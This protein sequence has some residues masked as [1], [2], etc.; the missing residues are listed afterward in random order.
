M[1]ETWVAVAAGGLLALG[2]TLAL[3]R[4]REVVTFADEREGRLAIRVARAV[5]CSPAEA[6]PAVRREVEFA[7]HQSDDT[8]VK[9]AV[10][11][12]RRELP[13]PS[14]PVYPD[15]APG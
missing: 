10:Y 12:Y 8:L 7:P 2:L 6:L 11:H 9:R 1:P 14:C 13:D 5:G 15:R 4:R 3:T